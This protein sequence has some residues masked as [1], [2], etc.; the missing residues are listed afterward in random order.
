MKKTLLKGEHWQFF[1]II[2][3]GFILQTLDIEEKPII[4]IIFKLVG[5]FFYFSWIILAG[6]TLFQILPKKIELNFNLWVGNTFIWTM[7]YL[8]ITIISDGKGMTFNGIEAI[9]LLYV[10][11]AVVNSMAFPARA[12]RTLEK[13][14]KAELG[15]YIGDFFLIL[16][17]P[18]GIW[19]L[20]PRINKLAKDL[21]LNLSKN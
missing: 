9:P 5:A 7:T 6:N 10:F 2:I 18:I 14:K 15:E 3:F 21:E 17:L 20:Q 16:F 19:F 11:Y 4:N 13:G 12:L 8:A 1:L